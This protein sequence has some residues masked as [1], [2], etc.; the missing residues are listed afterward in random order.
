MDYFVAIVEIILKIGLFI[1]FIWVINDN[2]KLINENR[3]MINK[4]SKLIN[5]LWEEQTKK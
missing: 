1:F 3:K 5:K 2:R 4:A